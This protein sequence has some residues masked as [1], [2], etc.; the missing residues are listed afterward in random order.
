MYSQV[1]L[2]TTKTAGS[3]LIPGDALVNRA[4]GTLSAVVGPDNVIHFRKVTVGRDYG[5]RI[6]I[7]EGL[8]EGD[9]V[10]ENPSDVVQEGAKVNAVRAAGG[11]PAK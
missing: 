10:V 3:L 5:D 9:L 1:D 8:A 7:Q 11:K 4:N 6:E 2:R